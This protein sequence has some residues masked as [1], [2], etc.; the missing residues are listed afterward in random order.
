MFSHLY[1]SQPTYFFV[2]CSLS[3]RETKPSRLSHFVLELM[4]YFCKHSEFTEVVI[5]N[6]YNAH[7]ELRKLFGVDENAFNFSFSVISKLIPNVEVVSLDDIELERMEEDGEQYIKCIRKWI[8]YPQNDKL[9]RITFRS[10]F[11]GVLMREREFGV[12]TPQNAALVSLQKKHDKEFQN[13]GW[14]LIYKY[15]NDYHRLSA[16]RQETSTLRPKVFR[17]TTDTVDEEEK[18]EDCVQLDSCE[19]IVDGF[20]D[21]VDGLDDKTKM[22]LA[23][24]TVKSALDEVLKN[25]EVNIVIQGIDKEK[26]TIIYRLEAKNK[27]TLRKEVKRIGELAWKKDLVEVNSKVFPVSFKMNFDGLFEEQINARTNI[28]PSSSEEGRDATPNGRLKVVTKSS[29][30]PQEDIY[31]AQDHLSE[32][33]E[34]SMN[35]EMSKDGLPEKQTNS[36]KADDITLN[37]RFK[38]IK[39]LADTLQGHIYLADDLH[40]NN[41]RVVLKESEIELVKKEITTKGHVV[42][43][44]FMEEKRLLKYLSAQPDADAGFVRLLHDWETKKYYYYS[45]EHCEKALFQYI[46]RAFARGGKMH[47]EIKGA[48]NRP[49]EP[50]KSND[51]HQW[52]IEVRNMFRQLVR[53]VYWLHE[54]GVVHLDIALENTMIYK[55]KGMKL[56]I[57]DFGLAKQFDHKNPH[58][59]KDALFQNDQR[60]GKRGYMAPEV[61]NS[62]VYD[63]RKADIWSLGMY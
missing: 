19:L 31:S 25:S 5:S 51:A 4:E 17:E 63:C 61:W 1:V 62:S 34:K 54:Q 14:A 2:D 11:S 20:S 49:Q 21:V 27:E 57:I 52:L 32:N 29:D 26:D 6:I 33:D 18:R 37:G 46:S 36:R 50:L 40:R 44:D 43:E 7:F 23:L 22:E 42:Q 3:D 53:T 41:M 10:V 58:K 12:K 16:E 28:R 30:T 39:K 9:S 13:L 45:M 47:G 38:V 48:L 56:K 24:S 8:K 60:V 35:D 55:M 59:A 15:E